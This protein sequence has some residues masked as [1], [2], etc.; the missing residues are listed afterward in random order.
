MNA[1]FSSSATCATKAGVSRGVLGASSL[2]ERIHA[3]VAKASVHGTAM[4]IPAPYT[5][6]LRA[7]RLKEACLGGSC[8][9]DIRLVV[10]PDVRV[11]SYSTTLRR[12]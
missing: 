4:P 7:R 9:G 12:P 3:L 10:G 1:T 11:D 5:S 2:R 6:A 8:I